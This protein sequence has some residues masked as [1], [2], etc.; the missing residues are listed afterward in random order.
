MGAKALD[1]K[2]QLDAVFLDYSEA[3]D[4]V[5][6]KNCLLRGWFAVGVRGNS[7]SWFRFDLLDRSLAQDSCR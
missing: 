7:L 6:F 4:Y 2:N 5:S 3:F 1:E